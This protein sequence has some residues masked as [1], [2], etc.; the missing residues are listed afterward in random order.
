MNNTL[1]A[2]F[3]GVGVGGWVYVQVSKRMSGN[4]KVVIGATVGAAAVA[5]FVFYTLFATIFA[6]N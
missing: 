4:T 5:F 3:F 2:L 1:V 6:S